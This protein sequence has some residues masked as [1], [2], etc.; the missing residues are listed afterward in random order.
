VIVACGVFGGAQGN[1]CREYVGVYVYN[2]SFGYHF[3]PSVVVKKSKKH[4]KR[5]SA[6]DAFFS[7][8]V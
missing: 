5:R 2:F 1:L 3:V 8:R 7:V 4:R 6:S